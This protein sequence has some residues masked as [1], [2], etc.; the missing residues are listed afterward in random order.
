MCFC[1][2]KTIFPSLQSI[3][4]PVISCVVLQYR[5]LCVLI[6][7]CMC[8]LKCISVFSHPDI[9]ECIDVLP[10]V[11]VC[12]PLDVST[13]ILMRSSYVCVHQSLLLRR[14]WRQVA[15]ALH[16]WPSTLCD[17]ACSLIC[18]H[19][20]ADEVTTHQSAV[21]FWWISTRDVRGVEGHSQ[22][23]CH[24]GGFW[25]TGHVVPRQAL[26]RIDLGLAHVIVSPGRRVM[27]H[28][29]G[30]AGVHSLQGEQ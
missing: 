17:P 26:L 30:H 24:V 15:F 4:W 19:Q 3:F 12:V 22:V 21:R 9:C 27:L 1:V 25:L 23:L 10:C 6:L 7:A 8:V 18:L 28:G 14:R 11:C 13:L 29:M 16:P 20:G 5:S 2:K